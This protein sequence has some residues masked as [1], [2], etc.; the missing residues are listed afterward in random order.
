MLL[1]Q[2]VRQRCAALLMLGC[3][4][5]PL[6]AQ[7]PVIQP[8]GGGVRG[9]NAQPIGEFRNY[10]RTGWGIGG[11]AR[12]FPGGQ[13]VVSLR[14]DA[15]FLIYGRTTTSECFGTGCRISVDIT[16]SNNVFSGLAG[17]ELQVP[18]G[19]IRPYVNALAG[20]TVFWTQSSADGEDGGPDVF[21]TTNQRDNIFTTA[22]GGGIR[23]PL[24]RSVS[25]DF[26]ARKNFNGRARYLTRDSFGD[27]TLTTPLVRESEVNMWTYAIGVSF[28]R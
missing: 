24:A 16:T 15:G 20:W 9:I 8:F 28:G 6:F 13:D 14:A 3:A 2:T 4:S 12:W 11:D 10:V 22:V 26:N 1:P 27:G 17:P 5:G 19:P 7:E 23:I 21:D 18:V 25:L